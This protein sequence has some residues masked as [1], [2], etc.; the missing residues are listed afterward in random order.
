MDQQLA[1]KLAADII[2]VSGTVNG[3]DTT[4]QY[5]DSQIWQAIVPRS[6]TAE[7]D[8]RLTAWDEV[9]QSTPYHTVLRY[10]FAAITN[11]GPGAYYNATDL[12]RVGYAV[13]FLADLLAEYGYVVPVVTKTDWEITDIP[14]QSDMEL[15]LDNIRGLKERYAVLPTTPKLPES[16]EYLGYQGANAIEQVLVD[17]YLLIQNMIAGFNQYVGQFYAGGYVI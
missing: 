14:N 4:W 15:Y 10:G 17:M 6:D 5:T 12:N 7:Y 1:V 11:R 16:M 8:I 9:G 3:I 2:F 13:Q